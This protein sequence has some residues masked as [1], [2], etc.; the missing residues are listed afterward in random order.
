MPHKI[1]TKQQMRKLESFLS[2]QGKKVL[3][4]HNDADGVSSAALF[5]EFNQGFEAIPRRGPELTDEFVEQLAAKEPCLIVGLDMGLEQEP[6]LKG[7][8]A[9]APGARLVIIDHHLPARNAN[10]G[11]VAHINPRFFADVY[12][13]TSY[14][15]Y[16]LLESLGRDVHP[17]VWI[18]AIGVIGDY[19]LRDSLSLLE[20]CRRRYPGSLKGG[21]S[22]RIGMAADAVSAAVTARGFRGAD[23]ALKLMMISK[24]HRDFLASKTLRSWLKE[25][26]AETRRT[27]RKA[28]ERRKEYPGGL[29][30]FTIETDMNLVSAIATHFSERHPDRT[31][32]IR[33]KV[34]DG[35]KVSLRSQSGAV[36][37]AELARKAA[38]G[39]GAGGGHHK[40]AGARVT[41]WDRFL[42]RVLKGLD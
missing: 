10:S 25:V 23:T 28:E 19:D 24:D 12:I 17:L 3:L 20:E 38:K 6:R 14:V 34:E 31:V 41:D 2:C 27:I 36:N 30:V 21:L 15:M 18:A 11:R 33:K 7:L 16:R 35:W 22:S 1:A 5:L 4:Y 13:S 9:K 8:L 39:I 40:A 32:I 26:R 42:E 29:L 37:V